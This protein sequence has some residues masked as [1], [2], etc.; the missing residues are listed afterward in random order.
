MAKINRA[1]PLLKEV[2]E[3]DTL[4]LAAKGLMLILDYLTDES[5]FLSDLPNH[6]SSKEQETQTALKELL[7]AGYVVENEGEFYLYYNL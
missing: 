6:T 4:T 5:G 1:K 3:N 7:T 2:I